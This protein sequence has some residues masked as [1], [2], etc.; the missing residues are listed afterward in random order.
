[1]AP[2]VVKE[3]AASFDATMGECILRLYRAAA[4]PAMAQLGT[5]LEA[6]AER[7]GLVFLPEH[8]VDAVTGCSNARPRP[9]PGRTWS[10]CRAAGTGG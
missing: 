1:M 4:Q 6:A 10:N 2:A 7:P 9:A 3:V 8:D 5:R